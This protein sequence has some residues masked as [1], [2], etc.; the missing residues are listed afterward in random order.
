MPKTHAAAFNYNGNSAVKTTVIACG[1]RI[2]A[3]KNKILKKS[4]IRGLHAASCGSVTADDSAVTWHDAPE[5][6]LIDIHTN[7]FG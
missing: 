6:P 3:S 4:K 5:L 2:Y 7:L 1:G